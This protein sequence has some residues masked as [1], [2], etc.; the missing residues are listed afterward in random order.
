MAELDFSKLPNRGWQ[1]VDVVDLDDLI[2]ACQRCG[3]E[4]RYEHHCCHPMGLEAVVGCICCG[5]ITQDY[6]R[7]RSLERE[8]KNLALRRAKYRVSPRWYHSAGGNLTIS[9]RGYR[10]TVFACQAGF[11]AYAG[12]VCSKKIY[13]SIDAAK[14]AAFNFLFKGRNAKAVA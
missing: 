6:E 5:D 12:E 3:T 1:L 9:Y 10:I 7:A 13:P 11:K 14:V 8:L 2:G 4:I